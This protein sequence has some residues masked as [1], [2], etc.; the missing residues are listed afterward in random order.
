M[1]KL[2]WVALPALT[3]W[4]S[5]GCGGDEP[6]AK[7]SEPDGSP[8]KSTGGRKPSGSGG[9][10]GGTKQTG[11][12]THDGGGGVSGTPPVDSGPPPDTTPP[13]FDGAKSIAVLGEDRARIGWDLATDPQPGSTQD[14]IGYRVYRAATSGAQDFGGTR[15]CG[16]P[17]PDSGPIEQATAPCFAVA[18]AGATSLIVHDA[19]P[20]HTFYYVVR[21]V[22]AAGNEDENT[23]E[24][25]GQNL[26]KTAP[27]FGGVSSVS[28]QSATS[29]EVGWNA[30]YDLGASDPQLK[31]NV[32]VGSGAAPDTTKPPKV[33]SK[34]GEHSV[35][36]T[37]LTPL[38]S[39]YVIVRA[40]DPAGNVDENVRTLAITT[41]E[42]VP[43]TFDGVKLASSEGKTVHIFWPPAT[44]NVTDSASML[45][46]VYE[47][48]ANPRQENFAKPT[49][50][51]KPGASSITITEPNA[52]TKYF[53]VVRARDSVG[54]RDNNSIE[55]YTITGGIP[56]ITPPLFGG[57]QTVTSLTPTTLQATWKAANETGVTY[58]VYVS[59]ASPVPQTTPWVV[60]RGLSATIAGLAP[61]T[62]YNVAVVAQDAASNKSVN[63]AV[64]PGTTLAA[65]TDM[66]P[67]SGT[68]TPAAAYLPGV[69]PNQ[70]SITW[71]AATDDVDGNMVRYHLCASTVQSDCTGSS[72]LTH[73]STTTTFGATT[74]TVSNL[75]PRTAYFVNVR[76]EDHAGNL[77]T[78]DHFVQRTTPT[79]W[80][81]NVKDILFDRCI[82][83]HDY[84]VHPAIVNIPGNL[85]DQA[86]C[87]GGDAGTNGCQLKLVDPNR[88]EFSILFRKINAFGIKTDPFT[89]KIPNQFNGLQEPRDTPDKLTP[90]EIDT[91][92]DW[93]QQGAFAN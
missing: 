78:Q 2:A 75:T 56:D 36:V 47:S 23:R 7:P 70:L 84:N 61:G 14:Q 8:A 69:P 15:R 77:E 80:A 5:A 3:L 11:G 88:P 63:P 1:T 51:S 18:P 48:L 28:V 25:S 91:I 73:L 40:A 35:I 43:P 27:D 38:T 24:V 6:G 52:G 90:E 55:V 9:A 37:G 86:A 65:T 20:A 59:T 81:A 19:V 45:Y 85:L 60:T 4:I 76:A 71:G 79:S 62:A 46:D 87:A 93:I 21:A 49:Y 13:S 50:T 10:S 32:Y 74:G 68:G 83:C 58:L 34:P 29:I 82:A 72:F 64:L 89:P 67:P 53:F 44:D 26:D 22:D 54:N 31:F 92:R 16:D 33:V 39:Y 12:A 41:P 42:G 30:G 66:S 57:V 17:L